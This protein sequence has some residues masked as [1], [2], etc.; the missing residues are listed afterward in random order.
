MPTRLFA[1]MIS[2]ALLVP[3]AAASP[4]TPLLGHWVLDEEHSDDPEEAF[5]GKLR[6]RRAGGFPGAGPGAPPP[7]APDS[8]PAMAQREYWEELRKSKERRSRKDIRRLGTAYPLLTAASLDI[9]AGAQGLSFLYDE[10]LPRTVR[11][12]PDGR[13]YSAS[14]EELVADSIGYTLSYWDKG[15][16]VL[17]TDPPDGGS[18]VERLILNGATQRLEYR[19]RLDLRVLEEPVELTRVFARSG[20]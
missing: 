4:E 8:G 9:S 11:P 16:L 18:Y 15:E 12:N 3:A 2:L 5:D 14:G 17:E 1:L 19:I 6:K 10:L 20:D 13:V 7:G